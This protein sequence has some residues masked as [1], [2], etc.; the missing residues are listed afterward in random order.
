MA[1]P[2]SR[3]AP[4]ARGGFGRHGLR[5]RRAQAADAGP[6]PREQIDRLAQ[7]AAWLE[8]SGRPQEALQVLKAL[9]RLQ[10]D[11]RRDERAREA[12]RQ[13]ESL[14]VER[15]SQELERLKLASERGAAE[16]A[17][18]EAARRLMIAGAPARWRRCWPAPCWRPGGWC[19]GGGCAR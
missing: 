1:D 18:R 19:C 11:A 8:Q 12:A 16:L 7:Q 9:Q 2:L 4:V 5:R 14:A 17:S 15:R 3:G 13:R 10:D 6:G